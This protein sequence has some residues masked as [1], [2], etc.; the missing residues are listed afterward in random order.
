MSAPFGDTLRM[1]TCPETLA[2][3]SVANTNKFVRCSIR[4]LTSWS[5]RSCDERT[6]G[7]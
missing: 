4:L 3:E 6:R 7:N 5:S 1:L 2:E